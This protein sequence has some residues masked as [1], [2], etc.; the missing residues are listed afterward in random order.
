M[1]QKKTTRRPVTQGVQS[2]RSPVMASKNFAKLTPEQR[3]FANQLAKN[4]QKSGKAIM[5]A[6]NTANIMA[7][8]EFIEL[9]P[10]FVQ[11]LLLTDVF[12]SVAMNSRAQY[13]PYFKF[14]I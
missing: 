11:K 12:G 14:M 5:G 2:R 1:V 8:P 4:V 7:K 3:V 6:T 9:L 13:I 10:I